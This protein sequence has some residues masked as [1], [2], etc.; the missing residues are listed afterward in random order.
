MLCIHTLADASSAILVGWYMALIMVA[1]YAPWGWIVSSVLD[2][3]ARYFNLNQRRWNAIHMTCGVLGL[4]AFVLIP[5]PGINALSA[6]VVLLT[7]ILVYWKIRNQQVPASQR[8]KLTSDG[9]KERM[10]ARKR[11]KASRAAL[12]HFTDAEDVKRNAPDRED[13]LFAIHMVAEDL[14]VPALEARASRMDILVTQKGSAITHT[15]DGISYKR[16]PVAPDQALAVVDYLKNLAGLDV[17]DRRRRQTGN[18][19]MSGPGG[20]TLLHL[21]T[22]GS[23][24]G[25][26]TRIDFD[27]AKQLSKPFDGI[28]LLPSQLESL[29]AF[30]PQH[31]RHGIVLIGAPKGQGLTTTAY[32]LLNRHDAYTANIKTLE[33]DVL[34][35]IEGVDQVKWDAS[36]PNVDFATNLQ[37]MLR[38]DP[39][40]VLVDVIQD[41]DTA[42]V[43]AEPGMD[44][45]LIYIQQRQSNIVDQIREWVK[46]VGDSNLKKAT[47]PLRA[48]MNQRLIRALCPNCRQAYQPT[49]E[50]VKQLNLPA[51]KVTQLYRH[52]GKVQEKNRIENCPVC[53]GS[54]YLGQTGIFEVMIIDSEA[55][56]LLA[57]GDLKAA[58]A[59]ARRNKM[60]YLQEAALS[61]VVSG[62][63][64]IDEVLRV[65]APSKKK[66]KASETSGTAA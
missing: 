34:L 19:D 4:A 62:E 64:S 63:T 12:V 1:V 6:V 33:R 45:P 20:R 42:P 13:P 29:Q 49:P 25:L 44:G 40:I 5:V 18:F 3:D 26:V 28:G 41:A 2:K 22:A 54:G 39:D 66:T 43:A 46:L 65:T 60:I 61:K 57:K 51:A 14:I 9:L 24:N 59:H 7:P 50:Q 31:D 56:K 53:G 10:E 36:D 27:I 23:S 16:D 58:L 47:G 38:R 11:S 30:E 17:S 55:K 15:V 37:S 48:V 52:S 35:E 8:F 32:S 21:T